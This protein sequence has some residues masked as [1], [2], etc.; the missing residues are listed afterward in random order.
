[1]AVNTVDVLGNLAADAN[2]GPSQAIWGSCPW[3]RF[4]EDPSR[5]MAFFD[6]FLMSGSNSSTSA[7]AYLG[8][9]GRWASYLYQGATIVDATKEGG[10]ITLAS[11]GDNEG[12]A[13]SASAGAFRITTT[14][15]LDLN[16]KLWFEARVSSSTI[17]AAK[18]DAFVGL[19]DSFLSSG[20]PQAAW[21]IQTTADTLFA[22]MN[23][24]GFH[25]KGGAGT[26]WSFVYQ[27]SGATSVYPTGLDTLVNT[28]LGTALTAGQYVKLGFLFDPSAPS[29]YISSASTGQTANTIAKPLITVFVNGL[30]AV[31]FLT[32]ANVQGTSFPTGFMAPTIGVMNQTGTSPGSLSAD[33]I[34]V[35]QA[36]NS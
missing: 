15:T 27:L 4:L 25:K 5:G 8:S 21:P 28:V 14:S 35:A 20:I 19:A 32:S 1:M 31:A 11:D 26:D 34:R 30:P 9:W 33:W 13:L 36:A 3:L 18:H 2:R 29:K 16:Q 22:N 10:V 17:A 12:V 7:A 23:A 6:D 24:I